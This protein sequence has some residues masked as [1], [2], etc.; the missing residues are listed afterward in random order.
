MMWGCQANDDLPQRFIAPSNKLKNQ[1]KSACEVA[2][3]LGL[4]GLVPMSWEEDSVGK[5][6]PQ[7]QSWGWGLPRDGS[8]FELIGNCSAGTDGSGG[9]DGKDPL[10]RRVG[11]GFALADAQ[12]QIVGFAWG[13]MGSTLQT[14]PRAE[15]MALIALM[16]AIEGG[17]LDVYVDAEYVIRGFR[18]G[19]HCEHRSNHWLWT[20]SKSSGAVL[21]VHWGRLET[22]LGCLALS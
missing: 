11:W 17:H 16:E 2:P 3:I 6:P 22:V 4:R 8:K 13:T 18:R 9:E 5:H 12:H 1:A 10:L 21:G 20:V 7:W 14:V 19:P 15:L